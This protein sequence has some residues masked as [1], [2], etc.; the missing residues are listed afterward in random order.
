MSKLLWLADKG[1]VMS[2]ITSYCEELHRITA[3]S[4]K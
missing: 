1:E 3:R 4:A 2:K